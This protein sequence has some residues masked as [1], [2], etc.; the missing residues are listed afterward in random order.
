MI[1]REFKKNKGFTLVEA[2]VAIAMIGIVSVGV[3]S[4]LLSLS[5]TSKLSEE[6]LK[7]NAVFRIIKENVV[8]SAREGTEIYGTGKI[9]DGIN[10]DYSDFK[11]LVV[12]DRTGEEYPEYTFDLIYIESNE[13]GDPGKKVDRYK[14]TVRDSNNDL[15]AEFDTEVYP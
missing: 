12:M 11:N 3:T 8:I 6:Y 1:Y 10:T 5:R 15:V 7:R 14:I 4:L 13:Y 9:A 2:I